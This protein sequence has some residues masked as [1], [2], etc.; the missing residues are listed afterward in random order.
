MK[1]RGAQCREG[2]AAER[3]KLGHSET[4]FRW[5]GKMDSGLQGG[6]LVIDTAP[7]SGAA[8]GV[9][10]TVHAL[11]AES[12][13]PLILGH[14][15]SGFQGGTGEDADRAKEVNNTELVD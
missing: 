3:V 10:N 5:S 4:L 7:P 15:V 6:R 8:P 9:L 13:A 14:Q 1:I 12:P 2:W 11:R